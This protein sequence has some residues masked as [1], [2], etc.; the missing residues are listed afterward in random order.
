MSEDAKKRHKESRKKYYDAHKEE[1]RQRSVNSW[2]IKKSDPNQLEIE[3]ARHRET[4]SNLRKKFIDMYGGKCDC[5]GIEDIDVLSMEHINRDGAQARR[6][7]TSMTEYR[8][9]IKTYQPEKYKI[10]CRN[11]NSGGHINGD[12]PHKTSLITD[13]HARRQRKKF[14]EMYGG[15]CMDCGE[16][17][18]GFLTMEHINGGGHQKCINGQQK[19]GEY[20]LALKEY[21]P[22]EYGVLCWNCNWKRYISKIKRG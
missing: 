15:K 5:C 17:N 21:R 6:E 18:F 16:T 4:Q 14:V 22:D 1:A 2:K 8:L 12:C 11:C 10:L 7:R 13:S 20:R 9:A 3:R 19:S